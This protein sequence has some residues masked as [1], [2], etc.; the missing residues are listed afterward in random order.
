MFV[1]KLVQKIFFSQ[2]NCVMNF[3]TRFV[4]IWIVDEF[5]SDKSWYVCRVFIRPIFNV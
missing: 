2:I 4:S 5:C 3:M 1:N